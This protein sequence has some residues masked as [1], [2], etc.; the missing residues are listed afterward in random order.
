MGMPAI[1]AVC[2]A[3]RAW[4]GDN[5]IKGLDDVS[6]HAQMMRKQIEAEQKKVCRMRD[7][8]DFFAEKKVVHFTVWIKDVDVFEDDHVLL[9]SELEWHQVLSPKVSLSKIICESL[10]VYWCTSWVLVPWGLLWR[11]RQRQNKLHADFSSQ[12]LALSCL[13]MPYRVP[14]NL[15]QLMHGSRSYHVVLT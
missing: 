4:L 12:T 13:E 1:Y 8:F 9:S 15:Q 3:I 11:H 6:M 7:L 10:M 5:N 2:E 14:Y